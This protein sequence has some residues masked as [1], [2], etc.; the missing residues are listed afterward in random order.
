MTPCLVAVIVLSVWAVFVIPAVVISCL[1]ALCMLLPIMLVVLLRSASSMLCTSACVSV[2]VL[3]TFECLCVPSLCPPWLLSRPNVLC[4]R[5]LVPRLSIPLRADPILVSGVPMV[6]TSDPVWSS[7][8][9]LLVVTSELTV[10]IT[11]W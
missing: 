9:V 10:W 4:D 1:T 3:T 11:R 2:S 8:L 7:M 5:Q 6:I